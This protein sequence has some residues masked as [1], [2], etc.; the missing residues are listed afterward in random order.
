MIEPKDWRLKA[1][2]QTDVRLRFFLAIFGY[3]WRHVP[4]LRNCYGSW[5][6]S[7]L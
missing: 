6:Q 4:V 1:K 5:L 7:T 2:Q 3:P